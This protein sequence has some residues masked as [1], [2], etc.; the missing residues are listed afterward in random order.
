MYC[1]ECGN[2]VDQSMSFCPDCGQKLI[3]NEDFKPD[4]EFSPGVTAKELE[5]FV[6][7]ENLDYYMS[8]W[9]FNKYSENKNSSGWNWAAFLFPIQWM[10]YRKMYMYVIATMLIN[11]LLCIII[12]NP[13]T[14]LITL[15]ICIFGG[16]YGNK[17]SDKFDVGIY[18]AKNKKHYLLCSFTC[19]Y[20]L[21]RTYFTICLIIE[22]SN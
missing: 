19:I 12:P 1:N 20:R 22:C 13:L 3:L 16:V 18:Y 8:K 2:E 10:G 11:L 9:K 6:G 21:D 17:L 5:L 4:D 7:R 14:P 15:G